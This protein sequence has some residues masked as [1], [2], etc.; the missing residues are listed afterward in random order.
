M[1]A[2]ERAFIETIDLEGGYVNDPADPGGETKFGISKRSYPTINIAAMTIDQAKAI[3][4][5]D[6]W[7]ACRLDEVRRERIYGEMFDTAVN[8]DLISGEIFDTAVNM[9]RKAAVL[10]AQRALNFLGEDLVED[11]KIGQKTISALNKWSKKDT[12]ALFI[13]LNGF[14]F[15]QYRMIIKNNRRSIKFARGWTKRIQQYQE[16]VSL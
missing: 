3:Y 13:C 8:R 12:K 10:I 4:R 2:F 11:G 16:K 9:G 1:D 6:Y 14:Q 5:R 15:S 7:E